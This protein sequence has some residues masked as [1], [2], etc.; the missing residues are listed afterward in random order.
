MERSKDVRYYRRHNYGM[1]RLMVGVVLTVDIVSKVIGVYEDEARYADM[2]IHR[3]YDF[4]SEVDSY[5]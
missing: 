1:Y 4:E 3:E 2:L 5:K